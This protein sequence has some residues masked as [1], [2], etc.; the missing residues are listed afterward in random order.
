MIAGVIAMLLAAASRL[1]I[2]RKVK[3][4]MKLC[5]AIAKNTKY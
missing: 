2:K 3:Y 5:V 4:K 1:I